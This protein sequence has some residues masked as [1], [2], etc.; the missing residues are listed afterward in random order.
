M[1]CIALDA[2]GHWMPL[3]TCVNGMTYGQGTSL[4]C[5]ISSFDFLIPK[6]TWQLAS[7]FRLSCWFGIG[8][9]P[10]LFCGPMFIG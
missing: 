7:W 2:I 5:A 8:H 4:S 3:I 6:L 1:V 10:Q 9:G